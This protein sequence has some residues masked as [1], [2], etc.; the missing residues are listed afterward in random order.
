MLWGSLTVAALGASAVA[1]AGAPSNIPEDMV[2]K[3]R[4]RLHRT[5]ADPAQRNHLRTHS[6]HLPYVDSDLQNRW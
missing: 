2:D 1:A 3:V 5:R 6:L 4:P